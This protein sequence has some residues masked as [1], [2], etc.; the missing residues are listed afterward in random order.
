MEIT[1]E[2]RPLQRQARGS[3]YTRLGKR[4]I[5]VTLALAALLL[6]SP[7]LALITLLLLL[8]QEGNPFFLQ[9]RVGHNCKPFNIIKFRTM[10]DTRDAQGNLL[11]DAER[12]TRIGAILR[13]TSLDELPELINVVLGDMSL[14]GP[15]P[16]IARQMAYFEPHI[17][18]HRMS[19][20]PGI[21]GLAQVHGRNHISF[22]RRMW[23]DL[24]YTRA[25]SPGLDLS[26][27]LRTFYKIAIREGIN[28]RKSSD[29][30][31]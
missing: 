24:L 15:R 20:R 25:V 31:A 19:V 29:K 27:L 7:L 4:I 6:L 21:S 2:L 16:W 10:N 26:I 5:D 8:F 22:R 14:I 11:P 18:Q 13:S 23:Y 30:A 1:N 3:L 12:T 17:C 9:Q 28:P